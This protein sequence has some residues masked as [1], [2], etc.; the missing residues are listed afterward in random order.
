M[1]G[2]LERG[3][4]LGEVDELSAAAALAVLECRQQ[5]DEG[6]SGGCGIEVGGVLARLGVVGIA[7][8]RLEPVE[9]GQRRAVSDQV[10]P[11]SLSCAGGGE[12]DHDDSWIDLGEHVVGQPE[13]GHDSRGEVLQH[14]VGL[15]DQLEIQVAAAWVAEVDRDRFLSAVEAVE[16]AWIVDIG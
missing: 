9:R 11:R 13:R 4:A 2:A 6:V 7:E 14:D 15:F 3:L 5:G 8:Q 10:A 16:G 1:R 12:G